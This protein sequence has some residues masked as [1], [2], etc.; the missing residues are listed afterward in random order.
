ME[1]APYFSICR[2]FFQ[3]AER[4]RVEANEEECQRQEIE[5]IEKKRREREVF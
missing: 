4:L 5:M 3:E 2:F 1:N